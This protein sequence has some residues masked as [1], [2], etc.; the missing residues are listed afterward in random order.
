[1]KIN[2]RLITYF[3]TIKIF[4]LLIILNQEPILSNSGL[5]FTSLYLE[6]PKF[7]QEQ[8]ERK[9]KNLTILTY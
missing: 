1:M 6:T 9:K 4:D 3:E 2:N 5:E 7:S 8:F